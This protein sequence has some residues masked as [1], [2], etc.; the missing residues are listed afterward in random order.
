MKGYELTERGKIAIAVVLA[1]LLII[2]AVILAIR[3]WNSPTSPFDNQ[4]QPLEPDHVYSP[5]EIV[6]TPQPEEGND[7]D[8]DSTPENG[9]QGAF[10]PPQEP[11]EDPSDTLADETLDESS[12]DEH[13]QNE[14]QDEIPATEAHLNRAAGTMTFRFSPSTQDSLDA[15]IIE[16]IADFISSPRNTADSRIVDSIPQLP[17]RE[18]ATIITAVTDAFAQNGVAQRDLGFTVYNA[19]SGNDSYEIRLSFAQ[20]TNR[21]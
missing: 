2:L 16:M 6:I 15:D 18:T 21:K 11:T 20:T 17:E 13:P 9:E 3:V 7:V 10:D 4:Q 12:E 8:I 19:N 14:T 5:P 1:I